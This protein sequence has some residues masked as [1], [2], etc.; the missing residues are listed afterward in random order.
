MEYSIYIDQ[1]PTLFDQFCSLTHTRRSKLTLN[2][3]KLNGQDNVNSEDVM[4]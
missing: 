4:P 3:Y 2:T 1:T